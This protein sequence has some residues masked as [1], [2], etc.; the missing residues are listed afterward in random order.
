[1]K[2]LKLFE[3]YSEEINIDMY[4]H[5]LCER[6][7]LALHEELGYTMYFYIDGEAEFETDGGY[8]TG[9]ALIHAYATDENGNMFDATGKIEE[10]DLDEHANY[11]NDG[12]KWKIKSKKEFDANVRSGFISQYS[13]DEI[14]KLR[15]YIR[16]NIDK[17]TI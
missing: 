16:N 11:V 7:A 13:K 1:M 14:K 17:Y 3:E 2:Y 8:T 12:I 15:R 10:D 6:F 4:E 9:E 5:G